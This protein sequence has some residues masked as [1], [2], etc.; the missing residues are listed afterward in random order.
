[1]FIVILISLAVLILYLNVTL[2][3]NKLDEFFELDDNTDYTTEF[4][5]FHFQ[6]F[7]EPNYKNR[8]TQLKDAHTNILPY[9]TYKPVKSI[10]L[11]AQPN[12]NYRF[13][14]NF[15]LLIYLTD[16]PEKVVE[17]RFTKYSGYI[18]YRIP[19]TA[20]D[21]L[22][23]MQLPLKKTVLFITTFYQPLFDLLPNYNIKP[24]HVDGMVD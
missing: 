20:K 17:F 5:R 3:K 7:E 2:N 14:Q 22:E 23:W 8:I 9:H 4:K 13:T 15:S 16:H 24:V 18:N 6:L 19:D 12:D 21:G 10:I 1:M 11:K